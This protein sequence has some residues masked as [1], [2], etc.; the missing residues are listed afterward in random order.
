MKSSLSDP[1][2]LD[3][4]LAIQTAPP[5]SMRYYALLFAPPERR[6]VL[7]ALHLLEDELNAT[8][9]GTHHDVAH[10]RLKWWSEEIDRFR[11]GQPAHPATRALQAARNAF[12]EGTNGLRG[13]VDAAAMDLA[14]VTY[15]DPAELA[16]YFGKSGGLLGELAARWLLEPAPPSEMTLEAAVRLGAL[17]REVE[18]FRDVRSHA[19]AGRIYFPLD[20][21]DSSGVDVVELR[22]PA[23]SPKTLTFL[24][25]RRQE[26]EVRLQAAIELVPKSER[27]GLRALLA[28]A[29]LHLQLVKKLRGDLLKD[30][31]VRTELKP[32]AKLWW[33]WRAA[34]RAP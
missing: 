6:E 18:V 33:A 17:M 28:L 22:A 16:I 4:S 5:G 31:P 10:T 12:A 8:A 20:L 11:R 21:L 30:P 34:R 13:I 24:E 14:R 15:A 1:A 7:Q 26:V 25:R 2:G 23:W 27:P 19:T 9:R 29:T 3:P 32:F